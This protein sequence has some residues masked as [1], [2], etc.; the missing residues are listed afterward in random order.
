M[1]NTKDFSKNE[2]AFIDQKTRHFCAEWAEYQ[3]LYGEIDAPFNRAP[4]PYR[5][6]ALT[7]GWVS[8]KTPRKLLASGFKRAE[9][10]LKGS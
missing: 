10:V 3:I 9:M 5:E 6:W 7:K 4:E 8:K 2:L 1:R